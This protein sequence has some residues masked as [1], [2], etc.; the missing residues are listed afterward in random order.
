MKYD[1][2]IPIYNIKEEYIT[3]CLS[4]V[5]MQTV[6]K[7]IHVILVDDCSTKS[8]DVIIDKFS[9]IL[10]I[11]YIKLN[12]NKGVGNARNI[13]LEN[14]VGDYVI[15]CDSDDSFLSPYSFEILCKPFKDEKVDVSMCGFYEQLGDDIEF[16]NIGYNLTW[17]HGKAFRRG[18]LVDNNIKFPT[19]RHNEDVGFNLLCWS[20]SSLDRIRY[21]D[22]YIH[23]W[24]T[25]PN[26]I[27]RDEK[28]D[29]KTEGL[30]N[31]VRAYI[32]YLEESINRG[33]KDTK[34]VREQN[35]YCILMLY[36][37][38]VELRNNC[39]EDIVSEF[40]ELCGIFCYLAI[41][42]L[43][44]YVN[45]ETFDLG[46]LSS[47]DKCKKI[48]GKNVPTITIYDWLFLI[49]KKSNIKLS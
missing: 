25:N 18:F 11:T 21:T 5:A 40:D 38:A 29:Y 48:I 13:G 1:L 41:D 7:D 44:D 16:N 31:F 49:A 4:S 30:N 34:F 20:C 8:S 32:W 12:E 33:L 39:T 22:K 47:L 15:F 9:N 26:S 27:T 19:F 37:Y 3:T 2:I 6:V 36:W 46:Y 14:T 42:N 45:D 24:R 10:N 23:I 43:T 17:L 35:L 28:S